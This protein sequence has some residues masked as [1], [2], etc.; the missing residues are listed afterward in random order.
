M[1]VSEPVRAA[2]LYAR[3]RFALR[4]VSR[5][6]TPRDESLRRILR[7]VELTLRGELEPEER[8]WVRRIERLRRRLR[9]SREPVTLTDFGAEPPGLAAVTTQTV[10]ERCLSSKS[11]LGALLLFCLVREL[12]PA[13]CLE[14]GTNLGVSAA[15]Q[16]AALALNGGGELHTVEGTP[17]LAALSRS[18]LA[19]LGLAAEVHEGRFAD[20][21]PGL[22]GRT[23]PLDYVFI[24]GHHD[25][26]ATVGYFAQI[27]PSLGPG[28]L[29]VFD[30]VAWSSG[31][32]EAWRTIRAD[33]RVRV[34]VSLGTMGLCLVGGEG[35]APIRIDL[36]IPG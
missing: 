18:H 25:G 28:A 15:Y 33:P 14:L 29:V 13:R 7:A 30:D 31:M 12:R 23:A 9:G 6:E 5:V 8:E 11:P 1:R 26:P 20:V 16:A 32:A 36:P 21:L 27:H 35:E 24:D 10:G 17:M 3:R 19:S 22:L 2:V 34:S 4:R